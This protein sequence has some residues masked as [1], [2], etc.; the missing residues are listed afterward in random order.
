[1]ALLHI[2]Y[3]KRTMQWCVKLGRITVF[4]TDC[5]DIAEDFKLQYEADRDSDSERM[6][7][8]LRMDDAGV[9]KIPFKKGS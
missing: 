6:H 8:L 5:Y 2:I 1:M 4:A 7:A 9:L 3:N